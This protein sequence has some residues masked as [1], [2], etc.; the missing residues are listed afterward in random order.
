MESPY[1]GAGIGTIPSTFGGVAPA[2][3][4]RP[5][6]VGDPVEARSRP[7]L[8]THAESGAA[9]VDD[10][11]VHR[12]DVFDIDVEAGPDVGEEV[13][14]EHVGVS[15]ETMEDLESFGDVERKPD[16]ALVVVGVLHDRSERAAGGDGSDAEEATLGIAPLCVLHLDD[17]STPFG[18]DGTRRR[19][20]RVLR[21]LD[22]PNALH[23]L[24]RHPLFFPR[25]SELL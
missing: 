10:L 1:A 22:D 3:S 16:T 5:V 11:G 2:A 13:G 24:G 21:D 17:V 9:H 12:A 14:H 20:E 6:P 8:S 7:V 15:H 4:A 23:R 25:R 19:H 18:Q